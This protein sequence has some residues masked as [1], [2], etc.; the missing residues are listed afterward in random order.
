M[1]S[2]C[3]IN[4]FAINSEW[5]RDCKLVLQWLDEHQSTLILQYALSWVLVFP[6]PLTVYL[7]PNAINFMPPL[8]QPNILDG[9]FS[10][11]ID[12]MTQLHQYTKT[13]Y[14][15][16][17]YNGFKMMAG[18]HPIMALIFSMDKKLS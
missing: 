4:E 10:L 3:D 9:S 1:V 5:E 15:S 2:T 8:H 17:T 18:E 13:K 7:K 6:I 12:M 11:V 16:Q 14:M